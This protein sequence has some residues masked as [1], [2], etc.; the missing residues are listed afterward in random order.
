MKMRKDAWYVRLH[1]EAYVDQRSVWLD[2]RLVNETKLSEYKKLREICKDPFSNE[3]RNAKIASRK[4]Y[5]AANL[6]ASKAKGSEVRARLEKGQKSLC[7]FFWQTVIAVLVY[8][9]LFKWRR[10]IF[11]WI[12]RTFVHF[13]W[14]PFVTLLTWIFWPFTFFIRWLVRFFSMYGQRCWKII[15]QLLVASFL[16][17]IVY[18]TYLASDRH[19]ERIMESSRELMY[20]VKELPREVRNNYH[21][22]KM[23]AEEEKQ[24]EARQK[25]YELQQLRERQQWERKNPE[26]AKEILLAQQDKERWAAEREQNEKEFRWKMFWRDTKDIFVGL[27]IF[28]MYLLGF[29]LF[30]L[31]A[32][33]L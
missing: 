9:P 19:S 7:P 4:A 24:D 12:I 27:G 13:I 17:L 18:G 28:V 22:W 5:R 6:E 29:F 16:S 26:K 1:I 21:T 20:D 30:L 14:R 25:A 33:L 11:S 23:K 8:L 10:A 2:Q 31:G 15:F 3:C 32:A